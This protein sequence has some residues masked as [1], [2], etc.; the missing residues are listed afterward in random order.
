METLLTRYRGLLVLVLIL[1]AQLVM[2]GVQVRNRQD[3][4]LVRVWAVSA[5]TPLAM[6]LEEAR[7]AAAGVVD[8]YIDLRG[9]RRDNLELKTEVETLQRQNEFLK[10]ELATADR[11][12]RLIEFKQRIPSRT[13]AAR[14][15]GTNAAP[16]SQVVFI[17]RGT[18][19]GLISGMAVINGTGVVGRVLDVYP[20]TSQVMLITDPAFAMGVVSQKGRVV[21]TLRGLGQRRCMVDYV[22]SHLI[23][24]KGEWF[25]SSGDDRVFPRGLPVGPVVSVAAGNSFQDISVEPAGMK[26]GLDEVLV[27][28]EA[29]HQAVPGLPAEPA[30]LLVPAPEKSLETLPEVSMGETSAAPADETGSGNT[31][32]AT[33][34][35]AA[36]GQPANAAGSQGRQP[37]ST[38]ADRLLDRYRRIGQSQNH[39]FGGGSVGTPPP[40]FNRAPA[41]AGAAPARP[42]P[43]SGEP[44]SDSAA[45]SAD[46]ESS[47]ATPAQ[48]AAAPPNQQ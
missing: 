41:P 35:A 23:V 1:A 16:S 6:I 39:P 14:I 25:Y 4:R 17:D 13:I 43:A 24:E 5:V 47:P 36:S 22:E 31:P 45:P 37:L 21:G 30:P 28:L 11:A 2:L 33:L 8:G 10:A 46:A 12:D 48:A 15:I 34:G 26:P 20:N 9:V 29:V 40:D 7:E 38:D 18:S 42:A 19:D 27:V 3:V 44:A 32:D